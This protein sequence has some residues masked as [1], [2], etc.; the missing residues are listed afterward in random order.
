MRRSR[1]HLAVAAVL[2]LA[3]PLLA[4][5]GDDDD[6]ATTSAGCVDIKDVKVP[7]ASKEFGTEPKIGKPEGDPPCTL[8]AEDLTDGKGKGV[9]DVSKTYLWNYEGVAWSTGEKFDSS[10][11][12]KQP[13]PF[14]LQ[15]V[16]PGWTEGL[17]GMQPG[18]RRQLIIPAEQAY[19]Q[20]PPPGSGIEPGETLVFVVDLVGPA[21]DAKN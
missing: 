15:Q 8:F 4:A 1:R 3:L 20:N 11:D 9:E 12:S 10:F 7:T 19:G 13:A 14:A 6:S 21:D 18:A 5:C 16:I 17:Q 2:A